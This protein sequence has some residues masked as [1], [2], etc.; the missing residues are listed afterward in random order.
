MLELNQ[1]QSNV[2]R[3]YRQGEAPKF[4]Q[5]LFL[6]FASAT[7]IRELLLALYPDITSCAKYDVLTGPAPGKRGARATPCPA[8]TLNIG[9]A[10]PAIDLLGLGGNARALDERDHEATGAIEAFKC[11]MRARATD[12]LGDRGPSAPANWEPAYREDIHAVISLSA[13]EQD[14]LDALRERVN[15]LLEAAGDQ[16]TLVCVEAGQH[17]N[18]DLAG[19]EHFG[20]HDGV[21]QPAVLGSEL[22][23]N[24]GD[25]T[26][27]RRRGW[28]PLQ[29]GEFVLGQIDESGNVQFGSPLFK[30]G[31][32]M[33]FRK[34]QQQVGRFRDYTKELGERCGTNAEHI[35]AKIIGRWPSGAPLVLSPKRDN[36][37]LGRDP[38][39]NND[40]RYADDKDGTRC[41]IGAHIRRNNPREDPS[42]PQV[43]QTKLHRIIRRTTPYGDLL[44]PGQPDDGKQRGTLFV[45]INAD[46][47]RQFEF[48]QQQ[49]I[50]GVLSSTHLTLPKDRDPLVGA[51]A[52]GAKFVIPSGSS[53]KPPVIAW[54]LPS[55]VTTRGGAYF[56]LPS[57][58][59]L[60]D[61]ANDV[62]WPEDGDQCGPQVDDEP[63]TDCPREAE[64]TAQASSEALGSTAPGTTAAPEGATVDPGGPPVENPAPG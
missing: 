32:F 33:V 19:K 37:K 64:S 59:A 35:G 43:A 12:I 60:Y 14:Q 2:L 15:A 55:F 24:P 34:L 13:N 23:S 47:S 20:F 16:I 40:F 61:I 3:G 38:E 54:D 45:V 8:P 26:P 22:S 42:G 44:P 5:Y 53:S 52:P 25:G 10:Y 57:L 49:W 4:V 48:L 18:G 51:Q 6:R 1:I 46:I 27:K 39:R 21:A 50:D 56:L 30:H 9:L 28:D 63:S 17:F 62:P 41:P 31:S 11:G 58:D 7:A 29:P 36:P